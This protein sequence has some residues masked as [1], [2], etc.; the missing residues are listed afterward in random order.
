MTDDQ[1]V[2]RRIH[3]RDPRLNRHVRHD[4]RSRRYP[5]PTAGLT[6]TSVRHPRIIPILDQ[7]QLGSCTGNAGIGDL[8]T[9]PLYQA[10]TQAGLLG[11]FDSSEAGAVDLYSAATQ[12]SSPGD[13]Y[14]PNDV[15]SDG[16]SI[17]QVLLKRGL[18]AGYQH[19]F[20]LDDC[21]LALTQTPVMLGID[22]HQAS[23]NPE[24]TGQVRI[25]GPVMGGHEIV[26]DEIDVENERVWFSNSWGAS[27]GIQ[28][29]AWLSWDDLGTLLSNQGDVTVLVP[30]TAPAPTPVPVPA[31]P[32]P[33]PVPTP[34]PTPAP[35]PAP[36]APVPPAPTPVPQPAPPGP[37]P[38]EPVTQADRDF[39]A[40]LHANDWLEDIHLFAETVRVI[41]AA[42]EWLRTKGL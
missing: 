17:A 28:G 7:G 31:P 1:L 41:E 19:T 36:P 39:A 13:S 2:I 4:P 16:L 24:S 9:T 10:L 11:R 26:A 42:R 30:V 22:W 32:A 5:Y 25:D 14:P 23:F 3:S 27:W 40:A 8:G 33:A 15:G 18:I 29:R 34:D 20:T 35:D 37:A 21:L 6:L 12:L 38:A